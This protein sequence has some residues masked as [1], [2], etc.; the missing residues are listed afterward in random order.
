MAENQYTNDEKSDNENINIIQESENGESDGD[1]DTGSE[2]DMTENPLYQVLSVL[3]ENEE[4]DNIVE[5]LDKLV[6]AV[7]ENTKALLKK[8]KR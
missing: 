6:I 5:V 1:D 8:G 7:N 4:G 2:I 3:F